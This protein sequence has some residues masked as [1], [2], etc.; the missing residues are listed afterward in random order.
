MF[1]SSVSATNSNRGCNWVGLSVAVLLALVNV[2][3]ESLP[4]GYTAIKASAHRLQAGE[5]A[6][7]LGEFVLPAQ[8][9][10]KQNALLTSPIRLKI[11]CDSAVKGTSKL[12]SKTKQA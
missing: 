10:V 3:A 12:V 6:A 8:I 7:E 2:K 4:K 11:D 9:T 5:R 1:C